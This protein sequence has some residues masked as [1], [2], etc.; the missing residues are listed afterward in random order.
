MIAIDLPAPCVC[1]VERAA[2]LAGAAV[3]HVEEPSR[4]ATV[5]AIALGDV[6]HDT[7]RRSLHLISRFRAVL[8]ELSNNGAQCAD[9]VQS[10]CVGHKHC[11]ALLVSSSGGER[12]P[13]DDLRGGAPPV[14]TDPRHDP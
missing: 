6:V 8:A 5:A 10:N 14:A 3:R 2:D 11:F 1:D 7:A 9:Q 12:P 13:A 4:I